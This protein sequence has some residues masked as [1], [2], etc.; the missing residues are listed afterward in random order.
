MHQKLT[1]SQQIESYWSVKVMIYFLTPKRG[2]LYIYL[3]ESVGK[4]SR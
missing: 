2:L 3:I 1:E 4:N